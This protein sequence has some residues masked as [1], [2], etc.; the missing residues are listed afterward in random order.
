[1]L[2]PYELFFPQ[3][4]ASSWGT[5]THVVVLIPRRARGLR[6]KNVV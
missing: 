6:E 5:H 2:T 1:M 4:P 3:P